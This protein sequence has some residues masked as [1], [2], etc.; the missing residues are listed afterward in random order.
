ME[1]ELKLYID[2]LRSIV[3]TGHTAAIGATDKELIGVYRE[4]T[5]ALH[6]KL[7]DQARTLAFSRGEP[8]TP[9]TH[10]GASV[11]TGAGG[12]SV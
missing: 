10:F 11:L 5:D 8:Y 12:G 4:L 3:R 1:N 9:R 6:A 2:E 7:E